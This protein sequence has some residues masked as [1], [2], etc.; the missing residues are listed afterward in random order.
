MKKNKIIEAYSKLFKIINFDIIIILM[1]LIINSLL[2]LKII[3]FS[4]I[5]INFII[6]VVYWFISFLY[7]LKVTISENKLVINR[8]ILMFVFIFLGIFLGSLETNTT[9]KI[10]LRNAESTIATVDNINKTINKKEKTETSHTNGKTYYEVNIE[11]EIY[12]HINDK[13]YINEITTEHDYKSRDLAEQANP[14]Y[15]KGEKITIYYNINDPY[16]IMTNIKLFPSYIIIIIVIIL[17]LVSIYIIKK[18]YKNE[19]IKINKK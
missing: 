17:E 10:F 14:K 2:V 1:L 3:K 18:D 5:A 9:K 16:D 7:L 6:L 4:L 12:Y 8:L 11:Y 13:Y 19:L 15:V